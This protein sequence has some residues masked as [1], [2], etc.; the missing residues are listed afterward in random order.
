MW[1]TGVYELSVLSCIHGTTEWRVR[2]T[3][4]HVLMHVHIL[5]KVWEMRYDWQNCMWLHTFLHNNA[6]RVEQT[7]VVRCTWINAYTPSDQSVGQDEGLLGNAHRVTERCKSL[8]ATVW[9]FGADL[10]WLGDHAYTY[11]FMYTFWPKYGSRWGM[12]GTQ[13]VMLLT[14]KDDNTISSFWLCIIFYVLSMIIVSACIC[15]RVHLYTSTIC[16][17]STFIIVCPCLLLIATCALCYCLGVF[18]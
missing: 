12:A 7:W 8:Y 9:K 11:W 17:D 14:F 10:G 16:T 5:T 13:G 4:I 15:T 18:H 2:W 1:P 3:G 6:K